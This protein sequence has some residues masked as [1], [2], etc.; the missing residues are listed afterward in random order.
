MKILHITNNLWSGGVTTLLEELLSY[1][2]KDNEVTLLLLGKNEEKYNEEKLK[3]VKIIF[4]NQEKLY[5]LK[6][7]LRIRK[8]IKENE[9]IHSHLFPSQYIT[10]IASLFLNKKVIT[11]EHT[12]WNRRRNK[13]IFK[14]IE[15]F[16]YSKYSKVITVSK[17]AKTNL[18]KW[19][20]MEKKI[21]AIPNGVD[22]KKYKNGK[23]IRNELWNLKENE[24]LLCMIARFS[25]QKDQKTLIK[26]MKL[27]PDNIKCIFVGIGEVLEET[28]K[29]VKENNLADRIKFLGYRSDIGDILNSVDLNILSTNY[30]GLPLIILETLA[31]GTLMLGS[32]VEGVD[33][34]LK[35]NEFLFE[36]GN[37]KELVK[38]IENLNKKIRKL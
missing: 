17:S 38:K 30:E 29:Y 1:F 9:I 8:L 22:L 24:K 31:T 37:E 2:S 33:E 16:I 35:Y 25:K 6:N 5:S 19:I 3:N 23:N 28:K 13:M 7:I 14:P 36:K 21:V 20:G 34:I 12:T 18:I 15:K 4:L 26:A 10:I 27:L 11:T 32:R